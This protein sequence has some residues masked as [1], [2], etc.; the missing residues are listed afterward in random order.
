MNTV[1]I[2]RIGTR[3]SA[4][5]LWQAHWVQNLLQEAHRDI[6]LTVELVTIVT[7]GDRILD[8]P[9]AKVGGKGLFV[10]ELEEALLDGRVDLAVHSMKDV[11]AVFPEGLGITAILE[12]EDPRD[13]LLSLSYDSL[14]ALPQGAKI[15]S[16]SLRRQSQLLRKR[17][18]LQ[19]VSLRGNVNTRIQRLEEGRFDAIILAAAGVKRL[20]M[21]QH[22]VSW[23]DPEQM[24]PAVGQGAVG[25]ETRVAD[26]RILKLLKPLEHPDTRDCV[27]AER[28]FLTRLEGGCQVPI[29]AHARLKD[30]E[31]IHLIGRVSSLDGSH[32]LTMETKGARN[33]PAELGDLLASQLLDAGAAAILAE[34]LRDAEA[35]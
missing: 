35:Q 8:A 16:S 15:G 33:N 10:K 3:G 34:A 24:I 22:V 14:E 7:K 32:A 26:R 5:A 4:L 23:I 20:E 17:P 31:T 21:T 1:P 6:G 12:R 29:A 2:L 28:A 18:D 11:P 19:M 25:V 27:L 13:A 9:L 30:D